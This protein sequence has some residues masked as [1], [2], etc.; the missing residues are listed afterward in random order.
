MNSRRSIR[1]PHSAITKAAG[2]LPMLYSINEL[3]TELNVPR[4]L[5]RSWLKTGLPYQRD[6]RKHIWII[7]KECAAWIEENRQEQKRNKRLQ[8]NQAY[9]FRCRKT[10]AVM[11]PQIITVQGNKRLTGL[12][13]DCE[14]LVNKGVKIDSQEQLQNDTGVPSIQK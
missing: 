1:L 14:G 10:I 11:N 2:L 12:C 3:C 9:C 4:H 5:I 13:P 6:H 8:K 7:G